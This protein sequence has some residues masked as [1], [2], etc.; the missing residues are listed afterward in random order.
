MPSN[1]MNMPDQLSS[2]V[3]NMLVNTRHGP[4]LANRNDRYVGQSIISY[5][6]FSEGEAKVF[7]Q[8]VGAGDVVVEAGSNIGAHTLLL[9]RLVG[10][11]GLVYA[12]EPQR[13]V[14]QTLCAN[15]ALNQCLNVIARQQGLGS[16]TGQM[17]LPGVDPRQ[18]NN[19]GGLALL[20]Q[21]P[22]ERV[23][24]A[25]IDSLSL[26]ACKLIKADV[27]GMEAEVLLGARETLARCRPLLYLENDR[28][29]KSAALIGLILDLGYRLW[30]HVTPLYN[31]DNFLKNPSN[32]FGGTVSINILCQPAEAARPVDA[33]REITSPA[34]TWNG[35]PA[36]S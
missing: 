9:S 23:D 12:Y 6:E 13:I 36:R 7:C 28:A 8:L 22:G 18:V 14:F 20:A 16:D 24:I 5:G 3:F 25:S 32:Q 29:E 19:F 26:P 27:E 34:D 11:T 15:L 30:W 17:V 4:M 35:A 33:M 10:A 21:G 31:P 1:A 2:D